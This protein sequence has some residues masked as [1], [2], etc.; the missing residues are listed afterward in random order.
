MR[1]RGVGGILA[2]L[3]FFISVAV[4][5][6]GGLLYLNEEPL[7]LM[8]P[9]IHQGSSFLVP[10]EEFSS[11][12]GLAVSQAEGLTILRGSGF[13]QAFD[14]ATFPLQNGVAYVSLDWMLEC[15]QGEIHQVGGDVYL[16]TERPQVVNVDASA[17]RV[18]V[19]L[20]RFTAHDLSVSQQA[21]SETLRIT[22]PHSELGIGAQL[23]RIGESEI[24]AVSM[25]D[26]AQGVKLS[27]TIEP[28]TILSTEQR[29]TDEFYSLSFFVTETPTVES[30]IDVTERMAVHEWQNTATEQVVNYVYVDAWRDRF[31]LVPTVPTAGYQSTASLQTILLET[32]SVAA[33]S[34]DCPWETDTATT[35]CLIMNGI[36]YLVPD[37]PSEV[38][39]LD[40]FGRWTAFS[41]LC[42]VSVKHGGKFIDVDGVNRPL[43]YGEVMV[44]AAGYAGEIARGIP[45]SFAAVKIR[46][47]RVVSVYQGPFVPEDATAILLVASGEAKAR[48]LTIQLGDPIEMVCQ[49]VH[50]DGTYPYAVS[51]GPEVMGD[52]ILFPSGNPFDEAAPITSGAVMACD[53]HG[54]LYLLTL[55]GGTA[56]ASEQG[57]SLP[58]I[59]YTLPTVIKDAVLLSACSRGA[60]AYA[61]SNGAFQLGPQDPIGLALS[62]IPLAP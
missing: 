41:S 42:S 20:T 36:P 58:D 8:H 38:L 11:C 23:I 7:S 48:L 45:G 53:W 29:E 55:E 40:L 24:Q 31:R 14:P 54:G 47:N 50:A 61:R 19:R 9:M 34:L 15:V 21:L 6:Q 10:L 12:L 44:Y 60:I 3:W 62:L 30:I 39:A 22:W 37:T 51:A 49:F 28:G 56:S 32:A 46:D 4:F 1:T 52:G 57:R 16:Q 35:E 17:S 59:L 43:A 13:K 26:S 2:V 18:T 33:I 5:A 27:I 25:V